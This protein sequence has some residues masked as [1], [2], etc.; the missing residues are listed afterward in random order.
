MPP[1]SKEELIGYQHYLTEVQASMESF[2]LDKALQGLAFYKPFPGKDDGFTGRLLCGFAK[3][4]KQL[5]KD[6]TPMWHCP[7]KFKFDYIQIFSQS[8]KVI[9]SVFDDGGE[10]D[11]SVVPQGGRYE[12]K[13]YS[14]C[15][16]FK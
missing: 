4:P 6:G 10:F 16:A 3:K 12:R 8:G 13:S 15:P 9:K 1:V 7:F 14:G 11:T 2:D 5:K